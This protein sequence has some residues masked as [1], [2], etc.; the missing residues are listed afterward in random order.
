[1]SGDSKSLNEMSEYN[2]QDVVAL[3]DIY[4]K[5][6]PYIKNH[7]NLCVLMDMDVCSSC[8]SKNLEETDSVYLT[9]A[10]KYPVYRCMGCKTPYIR[11]RRNIN[12]YKTNYR[13]IAR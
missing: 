1:M 10:S 13:S 3:E 11:G 12:N 9:S 7:P 8:G 5:I 6:R 4:L 2:K